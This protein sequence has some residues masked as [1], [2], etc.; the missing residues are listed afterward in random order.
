MC[1][2]INICIFTIFLLLLSYE[3]LRRK[4]ISCLLLEML[5]VF[6]LLLNIADVFLGNLSAKE[7]VINLLAGLTLGLLLVILSIRLKCIGLGDAMICAVIT[8]NLGIAN[9]IR[10]ILLASVLSCILS[11]ILL[12]IKKF[13][14]KY[15]IAYLPFVLMGFLI[16]IPWYIYVV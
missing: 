4:K 10:I 8:A 3:D 16:N 7:L 14:R 12:L 2:I 15:R 11:I 6:G 9:A 5:M 13:G 1:K